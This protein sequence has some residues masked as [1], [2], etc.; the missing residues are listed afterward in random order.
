MKNNIMKNGV[1]TKNNIWT[2]T[3]LGGPLAGG[4]YLYK[5]FKL[6]NDQKN[7]ILSLIFSILFT[8]FLLLILDSIPE[9]FP[10]II[11]PIIYTGIIYS[12]AEI[13]QGKSI[14]EHIE[15]NKEKSSWIKTI[16][17]SIVCL[18]ITI[19][20]FLIPSLSKYYKIHKAQMTIDTI[21]NVPKLGN[22][23]ISK[24]FGIQKI[25]YN[26]DLLDEQ[27]I[28]KAAFVLYDIGIFNDQIFVFIYIDYKDNILTIFFNSILVRPGIEDIYEKFKEIFPDENI[29]IVFFK[30]QLEN[31]SVKISNFNDKK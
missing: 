6:F 2:G 16:I 1:F 23:I 20:L 15:Q 5:N 18:V 9:N 27:D 10:N 19:S 13:F 25:Y 8:L 11:I 24:D 30:N 3:M 17:V 14:D 29:E 21:G 26:P 22:E 12:I 4:F 7:A 31:V 28:D